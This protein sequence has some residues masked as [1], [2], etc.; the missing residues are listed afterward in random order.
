MTILGIET[1]CDETAAAVYSD[2]GLQSNV[3]ASQQAHETYG[4]VVPELASR[5]HEKKIIPTVNQALQEAGCGVRDLDAIAVTR[6]PGLMGSLLVGLCFAKG[7]AMRLDL[8]LIGVDHIEAH[9]YANFIEHRPTFPL[10]CL[11]V[12]GGHTQLM[13]IDAPFS[14]TLLGKTRDD[15]AG[16]ACD[17]TGK[18]L[19]LPYPAGPEMDRLAARGDPE[20]FSFPRAMMDDNLEF[21]FSGLKTA[22]RYHLQNV[23]GDER[24]AYLQANK[25]DLA[26]GV[27]HA[28]TDVLVHKLEKAVRQC[29]VRQVIIAGGVSANS[30]LRRKVNAMAG[31]NNL[32]LH[33][34]SPVYCTDNAAMIAVTGHMMGRQGRFTDLSVKP[35]TRMPESAPAS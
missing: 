7:L 34:P 5:N 12:S 29:G 11:I 6:G 13:Y 32:S 21:S 16:E 27:M 1:S 9:A 24:E 8:P 17:K 25:E 20:R 35:Y 31:R 10:V 19:E 26:A 30:M 28:I 3:I 23:A 4:G 2:H 18:M 33:L 22:V 14:H 15:A